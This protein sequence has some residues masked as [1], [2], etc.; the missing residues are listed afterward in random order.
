MNELTE[1]IASA[2][3]NNVQNRPLANICFEIAV[4]SQ[5]NL[6]LNSQIRLQTQWLSLEELK[7]DV[8]QDERKRLRAKQEGIMIAI[9]NMRQ[10]ILQLELNLVEGK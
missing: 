4:E 10:D 1:K 5:I 3:Q 7:K 6:L 2:I 9:E 8:S